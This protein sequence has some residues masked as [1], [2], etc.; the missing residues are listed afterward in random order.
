MQFHAQHLSTDQSILSVSS[1]SHGDSKEQ[2]LTS[3]EQYGMIAIMEFSQFVV[4]Q[5]GQPVLL[6]DDNKPQVGK[7]NVPCRVLLLRSIK[8]DCRLACRG[9]PITAIGLN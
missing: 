8:L 1:G 7:L 5:N 4:T 2:T 3:I 9:K 6:K